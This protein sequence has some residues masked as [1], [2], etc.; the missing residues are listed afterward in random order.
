MSSPVVACLLWT[1]IAFASG[2]IPYSVL[3]GKFAL[4]KD[5]RRF[6]DGNPGGTNVARAGGKLWGGLAVFLDGIKAAIPV[7]LAFHWAGVD[8]M[9]L[10]PVALAPTLGHAYSPFLGF[11]GGKAIA[12]T[13]GVWLGLITWEGPIALVVFL[14]LAYYLIDVDGWSTMAM[15]AG[16]GLYLLVRNR[17]FVW[18]YPLFAPTTASFLVIWLGQTLLL[19]WKHRGDLRRRPRLR[20]A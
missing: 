13:A 2:S 10:V 17:I 19:A 5:I 16:F 12:S 18:T 1:A 4:G 9:W 3:V 7:W 11:R 8:G 15:M 6:G 14:L 20:R